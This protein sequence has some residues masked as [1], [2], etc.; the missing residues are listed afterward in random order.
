MPVSL[1]HTATHTDPRAPAGADFCVPRATAL[2]SSREIGLPDSVLRQ[3]MHQW[4]RAPTQPAVHSVMLPYCNS[5]SG[6]G[7][8]SLVGMAGH[9]RHL[10][11]SHCRA[12]SFADLQPILEVCRP[13]AALHPACLALCL[14]LT[15]PLTL[16][17]SHSPSHPACLSLCLPPTLAAL[18]SARTLPA[19]HSARTLPASHSARTLP[20]CHS[21][22]LSLWLP[23]SLP[24]TLHSAVLLHR[25]ASVLVMRV[26]AGV[27]ANRPLEPVRLF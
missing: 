17:A 25:D 26:W 22:C 9:L 2:K 18:H 16:L 6:E 13:L 19:S 15:L 10:D 24:R 21:A 14:P 27:C 3:L 11:I 1:P 5:L 20:A 4:R 8:Q 23:P 12:V 7:L